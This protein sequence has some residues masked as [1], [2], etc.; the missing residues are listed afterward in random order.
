MKKNIFSGLVSSIIFLLFIVACKKSTTPVTIPFPPTIASITPVN[1]NAGTIVTITGTNFK[2]VLTDNTVKFN[3]VVATVQSA[4]T[5]TITVAAPA[6]GTTGKITVA[7]TDGMATGPTFTY[8]APVLPPTITSI[9]P[10]SGG[11]GTSVTITGTNFKTVAANNTVKFN[12]TVTAVQTATATSLTVLAPSG[13]TTGAVTVT[14]SD[15]TATGPTFTYTTDVYVVGRTSSGFGYWKNGVFTLIPD[16]VEGWSIFVDGSDVYVAGAISGGGPAYW[17]NGTGVHLPLT[18]GHNDGRAYSIFVSGGDVYTGG[19]DFFNGANALPRCWKNNV[20]LSI[21]LSS[22]NISDGLPVT[23]AYISSV[24]VSGADVYA[25][26]IQSGSH[27]VSTYW[28]NGVPVP[29]TDGT[30]YCQPPKIFVSG[31]DVYV[32]GT[33]GS[34]GKYWKNG[35][36]N[37]LN[38]T[39]P[40]FLSYPLSIYVN[41]NDVYVS[42]YYT[43]YAKYWKNGTMFDLTASTGSTSEYAT[44][45]TGVGSDIYICGY[46]NSKGNG[47]WKNGVFTLLSGAELV[48]GIFVK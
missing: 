1:G 22:G 13:G 2:T 44:G 38:S 7:T 42:G 16:C 9:S 35:T 29:L 12:G 19:L 17:K 6:A 36:A 32:A 20:A 27:D 28:K 31:T 34:V 47:Y 4:T 45:I 18:A 21:P 33:D 37:I 24:F 46:D 14:T 5:T 15:G 23:S 41:N 39:N 10:V 40:A 8:V 30:T 26:G 25:A 3:G 11:V 43:K 48:N